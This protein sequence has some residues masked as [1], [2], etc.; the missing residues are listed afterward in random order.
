M[1]HHLME[2]LARR[3]PSIRCHLPE[4]TYL[5]WLNCSELELD[6]P[7]AD[8]FLDEARVALS[9]GENFGS[10]FE[11]F[12]RL[13]FATSRDLLDQILDRMASALEQRA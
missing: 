3:M 9:Q 2:V 8:F 1:H 7:A 12:A 4:A 5:A 10:G 11:A 6:G 13:N